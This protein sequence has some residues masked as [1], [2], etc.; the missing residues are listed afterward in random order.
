MASITVRKIPDETKTRLQVLARQRG[1]SIEA[2]VRGLLEQAAENSPPV[3][4]L[5]FP[6]NLIALVE[7][8]EDIEP[9]M[10]ELEDF[11]RAIEL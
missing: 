8:G 9:L 7:P 11:P 5:R 10:A 6:H 2:F 1:Q 3:N 4:E